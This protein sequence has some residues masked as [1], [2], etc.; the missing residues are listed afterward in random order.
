MRN[1]DLP[2]DMQ[3]GEENHGQT[4]PNMLG[5]APAETLS[6][7]QL[8]FLQSAQFQLDVYPHSDF[9]VLPV[10]MGLMRTIQSEINLTSIF[11]LEP[12]CSNVAGSQS[13]NM[14]LEV[15]MER[16]QPAVY[17]HAIPR[18]LSKLTSVVA[19]LGAGL[20]YRTMH[21]VTGRR[22]NAAMTSCV[23]TFNDF[24]QVPLEWADTNNG[25]RVGEDP[26]YKAK[27][28]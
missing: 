21:D 6:S 19:Y 15:P 2:P 5:Y 13:Q 28:L 4:S 24:E 23:H 17:G 27:I 9:E 25:M 7:E 11:K 16:R 1:W 26:N 8:R 12:V 14:I 10:F 18:C 3:P 22:R 20:K